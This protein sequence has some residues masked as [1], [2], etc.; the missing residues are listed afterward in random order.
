MAKNQRKVLRQNFKMR[1]KNFFILMHQ[2]DVDLNA[3]VK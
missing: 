1:E 2:L 3:N